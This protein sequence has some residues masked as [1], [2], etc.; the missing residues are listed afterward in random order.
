MGRPVC[1]SEVSLSTL[2]NKDANYV[3]EEG[4]TT[5]VSKLSLLSKK[6]KFVVVDLLKFVYFNSVVNV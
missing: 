2:L 3:N 5:V 4:K 1:R 6:M